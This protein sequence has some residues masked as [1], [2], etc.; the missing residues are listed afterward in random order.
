MK[1][2]NK[3]KFPTKTERKPNLKWVKAVRIPLRQNIYNSCY[4]QQG[5]CT[6]VLGHFLACTLPILYTETEMLVYT[7][8]HAS[9]RRIDRLYT[10]VIQGLNTNLANTFYMDKYILGA[11]RKLEATEHWHIYCK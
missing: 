2:E 8:H 6:I 9:F 5:H 11:H 7:T 4:E 3:N 1:E 10:P